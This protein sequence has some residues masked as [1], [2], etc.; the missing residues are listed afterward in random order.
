MFRQKHCVC[1]ARTGGGIMEK[2]IRTMMDLIAGEVC[3][4]EIEK[5]QYNLTNEEPEKL[6]DLSKSHDLV[7]LVGDALIK[8]D[9]IKND[10]IKAK[11][12]KQIMFAVYRYE[13]LNYELNCLRAV[14]NRM[15]IP[16]IPLKGSVIRRYYPEPWMRTSGD[17]DILV[18]EAQA[19]QASQSIIDT[20]GYTY[21]KRSYHDITLISRSGI[22]LE[23]HFSIKVH[24][25][26]VDMLLANCWD[27][28]NVENESEYKL[29][30]EF[31]V[32]H[33]YAHALYH[34]LNGGC[35]IRPVLDIYLLKTAFSAF[36]QEKLD[37][38]LLKT[39]IKTFADA[40]SQLS[41]VWFGDGIHDDVTRRMECFILH[42]GVYGNSVNAIA[43][44][45]QREHGQLGYILHSLWMPYDLLC[46]TYPSLCGRRFLQPF[47]EVKRWFK[48][49]KPEVRKRR[50]DDLNTI[51]NL[52][53]EAINEVD[54]MLRD[55]EL[56]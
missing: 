47:Y 21:K 31:F 1:N 26:K 49:L 39:G 3:G 36:D 2:L 48:V 6:Y 7:H 23:L 45:Q 29:C 24:K 32:F 43:V 11:F 54:R 17:I 22:C 30:D 50:G 44:R 53:T 4:K 41:C 19:D 38:M 15:H 5:S 28:T 18:H 55:L 25:E 10:E 37:N 56:I 33:Q 52:S 8:N 35:G 13:R 16:F 34:F 27:Y 51:R 46:T 20:L 42:G 9:L 14:L 40:L 12:E